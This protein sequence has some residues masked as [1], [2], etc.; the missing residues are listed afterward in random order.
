MPYK[1][2]RS[3]K[4]GWDIIKKTTGKVVAHSD[5][6]TKAKA[7]IGYRMSGEKKF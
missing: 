3:K 5:T 6:M 1:I 2:R 7:S 4:G